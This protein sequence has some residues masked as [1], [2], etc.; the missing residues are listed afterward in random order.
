MA[1]YIGK[2]LAT[3]GTAVDAYSKTQTDATYLKLA[4]GLMTGGIRQ[5][6]TA[7]TATSSA[8]TNITAAMQVVLVTTSTYTATM[9]LPSASTVGGQVYRFIKVDSGGAGVGTSSTGRVIIARAGSDTMGI[10]A[11]TSMQLWYQ[12][13]YVD[14]MSD[15]TSRWIVVSTEMFTIPEASRGATG[16]PWVDDDTI[17]TWIDANYSTGS[18]IVPAGTSSIKIQ[19]FFRWYGSSGTADYVSVYAKSKSST[20]S[21]SNQNAVM[22]IGFMDLTDNKYISTREMFTVECDINRTFQWWIHDYGTPDDITLLMW[23]YGYRLG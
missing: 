15:G 21:F 10:N 19:S 2:S 14:L 18:Q 8:T 17:D 3:G 1:G 23:A 22:T 13:N 12:D 16:N 11:N 5:D 6:V 4:G 7:I 9:Q 20:S